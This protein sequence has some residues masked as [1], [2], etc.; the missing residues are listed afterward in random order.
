MAQEKHPE[1]EKLV[2][3]NR[4]ARHEYFIEHT[5]EAGLELKGTEVKSLRQGQGSIQESFAQIKGGE[6]WIVQFHIPPYEQANR[7]NQDPVRT[8]R[9]LMHRREIDK[10]GVAIEQK[11]HTLVPLEVYFRKGR[12][13][14]LIGVARGKKSFDKRSSLKERDM[15]REMDRALRRGRRNDD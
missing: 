1:R 8:R 11:G 13:K 10:L 5:L 15:A 6:A 12:V 9:L 2:C 7:F 4:K 14:V 3:Q